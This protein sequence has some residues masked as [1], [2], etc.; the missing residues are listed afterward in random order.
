MGDFT[1]GRQDWNVY[2]IYDTCSDMPHLSARRAAT[3]AIPAERVYR[4]GTFLGAVE[5]SATW[6]CGGMEVSG[7]YM[8]RPEVGLAP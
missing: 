8:N 7:I 1:T 6:A 2:D 4:D 3:S 5:Y